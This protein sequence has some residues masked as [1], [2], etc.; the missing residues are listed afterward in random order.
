MGV[1]SGQLVSFMPLSVRSSPL[2]QDNVSIIRDN[3]DRRDGMTREMKGGK[4]TFPKE[5]ALANFA[6]HFMVSAQPGRPNED[7]RI[8]RS[9]KE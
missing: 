7:E 4:Q 5:D 1:T 3:D 2:S 9:K 6:N 8:K